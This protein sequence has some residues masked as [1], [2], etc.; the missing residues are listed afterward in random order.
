MNR[1]ARRIVH[2]AHLDAVDAGQPPTAGDRVAQL[3]RVAAVGKLFRQ[4]RG[5]FESH[6]SGSAE[7]SDLANHRYPPASVS[8]AFIAS[9]SSD[10]VAGVTGTSGRRSVFSKP[11]A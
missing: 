8:S 7:K 11:R 9:F 6:F 3:D 1:L 2:P 10:S 5:H 4:D